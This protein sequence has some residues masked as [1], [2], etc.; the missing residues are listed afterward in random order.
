M[1][2]IA[3]VRTVADLRSRIRDWR[4]AGDTVGLVPTMGALHDGHMALAT[5][6]KSRCERTVATLFVNPK[7]FGENEDFSVYPR[8]ERKDAARLSGAGVDLLFAPGVDEMYPA[9]FSTQISI[10][11]M[12]EVLEG[13]HR[14]GFFTGVATIVTKLLLQS[15]PDIAFFGEKDFQ[16]LQVIR[17]LTADLDIP[18]EIAGIETVRE[19]DGLAMSSRNAYLSDTE[20]ERASALHRALATLAARIARGEGVRRP[21]SLKPVH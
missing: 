6:A 2:E 5:A 10:G 8:D 9:G 11:P 21:F 1:N 18:V 3:V 15:L 19:A 13:E 17:R 12:G 16:Q 20:R 4:A 7:Q 14:P